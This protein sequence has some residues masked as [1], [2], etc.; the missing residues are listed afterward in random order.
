MRLPLLLVSISLFPA[1]ALAQ[2]DSSGCKDPELF[3]RMPGHFIERCETSP[4][5]MRKFPVGA[6]A[7]NGPK[8]VEVEGAW[9]VFVYR[10]KEGTPAASPLQVQR[11]F[12]NAVKAAG[13]T[14]E[15]SYPEWCK[16]EL[17]SS[18]KLGNGCTESGT[19]LKFTK[20]GKEAWVFVDATSFGKTGHHDGYTLYILEKEAMA[21]DIVAN[22]LLDKINKDGMVALYLNFDTNSATLQASSSSQLD[23]IATMLKGAATLNVEVAGHTDNVGDAAANLKL[24]QARAAAVA[25]ALTDRGIAAARLT[26]KGYGATAPVADNRTEDGRG[27]NR[28]VE[29]VKREGAPTA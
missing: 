11:N 15:G 14:V 13:G 26:P 23:Q 19:T 3:N 29:L 6:M 8:L 12:Q 27:K 20:N 17:D 2:N 28:R 9:R 24:S 7:A 5:E 18:F 21:Q 4:F 25:K 22:E 10:P 1:V 16:F